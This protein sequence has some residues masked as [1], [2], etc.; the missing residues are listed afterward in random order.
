MGGVLLDTPED[1]AWFWEVHVNK[2]VPPPPWCK[3]VALEGNE[4]CPQSAA[5]FDADGVADVSEGPVFVISFL[6]VPS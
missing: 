4:D 6:R 1:I 5:L 3:A 2:T